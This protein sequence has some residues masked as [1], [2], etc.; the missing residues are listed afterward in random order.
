MTT[1]ARVVAPGQLAETR[2]VDLI[3]RVFAGI[4][5]PTRLRILL[6]LLEGQFYKGDTVRI[7]MRDSRRHSLFGAIEQTMA[8]A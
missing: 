5:D 2:E 8:K 3:A 6:L 7:E 4:S 1:T